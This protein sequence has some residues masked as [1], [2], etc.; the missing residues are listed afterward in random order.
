MPSKYTKL[1]ETTNYKLNCNQPN[2]LSSAAL[3]FSNF[4]WTDIWFR[5]VQNVLQHICVQ[6]RLCVLQVCGSAG[7]PKF[8][9]KTVM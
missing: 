2:K 8:N 1:Q 9:W 5:I 3:I 6:Y 7:F 4:Y